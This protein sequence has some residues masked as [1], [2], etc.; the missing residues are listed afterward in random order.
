MKERKQGCTKKVAAA[1]SGFSERSVYRTQNRTHQP[2]QTERSWKT[3]KDPFEAVWD[4][5]IVS[6]L[7]K[8][9]KLQA[10]TILEELQRLYPDDFPESMLRTL[11]RRVR[12]WQDRKSTRLNSSHL[13]LSRMPSS[14]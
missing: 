9:P 13:K 11:Y 7:E 4:S 10:K 14:A 1:R 12:D 6:M 3:R 2:V 8:A 5:V